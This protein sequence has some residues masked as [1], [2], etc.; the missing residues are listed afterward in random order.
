M[1]KGFVDFNESDGNTQE[2]REEAYSKELFEASSRCDI[3]AAAAALAKG[4]E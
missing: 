2:E 3:R 1:W 4:A